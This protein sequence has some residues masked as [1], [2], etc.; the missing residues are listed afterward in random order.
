MVSGKVPYSGMGS[1]QDGELNPLQII[2]KATIENARPEIP[3]WTPPFLENLI[4]LCWDKDPK[5]RPP[6]QR[7]IDWFRASENGEYIDIKLEEEELEP[8][9]QLQSE[10]P[11]EVVTPS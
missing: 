7:I 2:M 11:K 4:K 1:K 9:L 3:D 5:V 10:L 6:F 8:T